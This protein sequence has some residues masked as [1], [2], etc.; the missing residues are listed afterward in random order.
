MARRSSVDRDDNVVGR[1]GR[2]IGTVGPGLVGEV[3]LAVRGGSEAF[4][5]YPY[6]GTDTLPIGTLVVVMEYA[7]PR[8][9]YVSAAQ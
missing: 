5:A 4:H 2:V 8:I 9:V 7:Q 3:M 6:I 1:T